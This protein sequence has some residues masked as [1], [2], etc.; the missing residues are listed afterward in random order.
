MI[1]LDRNGQVDFRDV[2]VLVVDDEQFSRAIVRQSLLNLG[3]GRVDVA[4]HGGQALELLLHAGQ[5]YD[6]VVSDVRMPVM[7]GM[8]LLRRV[9][10]GSRGVSRD[11]VFG[12][13][14]SFSDKEVIGL[15]FNLDV[16][17][18]VAKPP[19]IDGLKTRLSKAM[20]TSRPIK[21]LGEYTKL[22]NAQSST[23]KRA[24][25]RPARPEEPPVEEGSAEPN[26]GIVLS[27]KR[28]SRARASPPAAASSSPPARAGST[29]TGP[30][31][32]RSIREVTAG[33]VL[34]EDLRTSSGTLILQSGFVLTPQLIERLRNLAEVDPEVANLR[35]AI[36]PEG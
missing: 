13:L 10:C 20:T 3:C 23:A 18:F 7:D 30:S 27:S 25:E 17:F 14:T 16:D 34:G 29:V 35:V 22:A 26:S 19:T 28:P 24:T 32:T 33:A 8:E 12:I 36:G 4:E 1:R 15:A 11:I 21:S 9:R 2:G 6:A 31:V 5:S